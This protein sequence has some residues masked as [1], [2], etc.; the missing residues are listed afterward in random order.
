[1]KRGSR[2]PVNDISQCVEQADRLAR[3]LRKNRRRDR[4]IYR[5][6]TSLAGDETVGFLAFAIWRGRAQ[7]LS[8]MHTA[9]THEQ[10]GADSSGV[11]HASSCWQGERVAL[12]DLPAPRRLAR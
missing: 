1:M 10:A 8:K 11:S 4:A 9:P 2:Y 5:A 12:G 3:R 6:F 7:L